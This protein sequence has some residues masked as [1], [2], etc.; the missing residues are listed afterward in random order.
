[1]GR[2]LFASSAL[3]AGL[4]I[5][6]GGLGNAASSQ[7]GVRTVNAGSDL[8]QLLNGRRKTRVN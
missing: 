6:C 8:Q 1:M 3:A 4:F 2:S 7:Q 5:A